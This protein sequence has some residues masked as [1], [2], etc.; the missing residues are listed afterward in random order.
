MSEQA[1]GIHIDTSNLKLPEPDRFDQIVKDVRKKYLGEIGKTMLDT[2]RSEILMS[3]MT[4][5]TGNI[6][7]WQE[8]R[9]RHK[10]VA[11][12]PPPCGDDRDSPGHISRYL[13]YGHWVREPAG[14]EHIARVSPYV[15]GFR[16]YMSARVKLRPYRKDV[17]NRIAMEVAERFAKK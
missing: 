1:T 5:R 16:F 12:S 13:D 11:V 17:A 3:G 4:I 6:V 15:R 9:F 14:V 2:V 7:R 8:V 10:Y